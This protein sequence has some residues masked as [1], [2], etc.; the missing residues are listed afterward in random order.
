MPE[1]GKDLKKIMFADTDK[2]HADLRLKLRRDGLSQLFFFQSIVSGYINN[3]PHI[4]SFVESVKAKSSRIGKKKIHKTK[5][6]IDKGNHIMQQLGLS[7]NDTD[8]IYDLIEEGGD[9]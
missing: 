6:E 3:D 7:D 1:Y 8:F 2:R 9:I 4:A 5:N